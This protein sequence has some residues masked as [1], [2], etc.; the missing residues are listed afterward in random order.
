M[1]SG[2][3][4]NDESRKKHKLEHWQ[5]VAIVLAFYDVA[6]VS[7][8]YF[9]AL[10]LRFDTTYSQI[11]SRYINAYYGFFWIYALICLAVFFVFRL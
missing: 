5:E 10:W 6:A 4:M 11:P 9:L 8:S 3:I 2:G 7:L 1:F